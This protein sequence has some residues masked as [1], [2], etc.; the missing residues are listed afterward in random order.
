M[1]LSNFAVC[2]SKKLRFI[3]DQETSIIMGSLAKSLS[4][5]PIEGSIS[6]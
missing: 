1:L 3:K 5:I 2:R 6:F 4:Q